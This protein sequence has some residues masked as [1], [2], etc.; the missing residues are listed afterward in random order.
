MEG[1]VFKSALIAAGAL[2][3]GYCNKI[4]PRGSAHV[5][6]KD[7]LIIKSRFKTALHAQG[8]AFLGMEPLA[9]N[10]FKH[11]NKR[12]S[13][14]AQFMW[15]SP[16]QCPVSSPNKRETTE[17]WKV[18]SEWDAMPLKSY[19]KAVLPLISFSFHLPHILSIITLFITTPGTVFLLY[20]NNYG[21]GNIY[22]NTKEHPFRTLNCSAGIPSH[23]IQAGLATRSIRFSVCTHRGC[24]SAQ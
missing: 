11:N 15:S 14:V 12:S 20:S 22:V 21:H 23:L 7:V 1:N 16:V 13:L 24:P 3:L 6:T 19:W 8:N 9:Q 4:H 5:I 17:Q 10:K 18:S 2:V